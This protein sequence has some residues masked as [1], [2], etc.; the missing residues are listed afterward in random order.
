MPIP[1]AVGQQPSHVTVQFGHGAHSFLL[2]QGATLY[3]LAD[4]IEFLGTRHAG[5]PT[6]IAVEFQSRDAM[7]ESPTPFAH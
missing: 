1:R 4:C 6:S 2:S 7:P 5:A 3:D